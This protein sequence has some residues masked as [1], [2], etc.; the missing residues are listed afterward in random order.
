ML[1]TLPP[2]YQVIYNA[3]GCGATATLSY[4]DSKQT[5]FLKLRK[6]AIFHNE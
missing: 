4:N 3:L 2:F 5:V 6:T 1:N